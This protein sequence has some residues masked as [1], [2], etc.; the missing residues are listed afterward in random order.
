MNIK[1]LQKRGVLKFAIN[2]ITSDLA[3]AIRR[4]MISEVPTMAIDRIEVRENSSVLYDEIIA[5]RTGL[6][7]LS[8]GPG[9]FNS[10]KEC[11]CGGKGCPLCEVVFALEKTGPCIVYSGD[12]KSSNKSVQPTD[13]R[14]PIVELLK[15]QKLKLE[16]IARLG[17]G[18]EHIKF[19]AAI[20]GYQNWPEVKV[21][22]GGADLNRAVNA[23][24]KGLIRVSG[25][26]AF[27][28]EPEK[29]D[30]CL[31]CIEESDGAVKIVGDPNKF[32]FTVE[33][34]SGLEPGYIVEK[35]AEILEGKGAEFL[36][37]LGKI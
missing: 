17:S 36:K 30:L 28:E 35:A 12:M 34:V 23:C 31:K 9:K 20:T 37:E 4:I 18:K 5:H 7:P 29:C 24:P 10:Q 6:I 8:F 1:V 22:N 11:K 19:Q 15:N 25:K 16:A 2:G 32:I 13:G 26:K 14:F 33:S 3:N 21:E 27:I